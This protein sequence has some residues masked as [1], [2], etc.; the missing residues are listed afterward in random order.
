MKLVIGIKKETTRTTQRQAGKG[1]TSFTA[2]LETPM[3]S[4]DDAD[5]AASP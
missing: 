4:F 3:A 5:I 1:I 2:A